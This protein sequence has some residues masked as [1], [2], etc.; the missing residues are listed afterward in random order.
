M[1][2][3]PAIDLKNGQCVRLR[4][5]EAHQA[6]VYSEN[7][8]ALAKMFEAAGAQKL[9]LV[10]LDG[11]FAGKTANLQS[12]QAIA[13]AVSIPIELGGGIRT[14]Q[15]IETL[16][17]LQID[18]VIVGTMAVK[19]P[20][21]LKAALQEFSGEQII[22]GIDSRHGKVAV[23]GWAEQ[24]EID[25]VEFANSWKEHGVERIIFTD[26]S[27]DGMLSGPNLEALR[28]FALGTQMK[29]TASGGVA[30]QADLEQLKGLEALGVDQVIVGKAIYEG[31]LSLQEALSC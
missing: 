19:N 25:G 12:I 11:A 5:G 18:S 24:T 10:D 4:Q 8:V 14:Q 16:L 27:R 28:Q 7:P 13:K 29:I 2:V 23:E 1:I 22:L 6:T 3:L 31:T 15:D 26:I 17:G 9:H 20:S 30:S 21:I